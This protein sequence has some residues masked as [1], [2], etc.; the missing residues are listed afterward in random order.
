VGRLKR[1]ARPRP[2][3]S[4]SESVA[5]ADDEIITAPALLRW[6]LLPVWRPT[7]VSVTLSV[8]HVAEATLAGVGRLKAVKTVQLDQHGRRLWDKSGGRHV[9]F[10]GGAAARMMAKLEAFCLQER[11]TTGHLPVEQRIKNFVM[12]KLLPAEGVI[13]SYRIARAGIVAPILRKLKPPRRK[14]KL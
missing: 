13:S 6:R 3:Q 9:N 14:N 8:A 12:G 4:G 5:E 2:D 10:D 1:P 11:A 7:A